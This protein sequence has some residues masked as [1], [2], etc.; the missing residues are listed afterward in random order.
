MRLDAQ[1]VLA[2][3]VVLYG[4]FIAISAGNL[5]TAGI[6]TSDQTFRVVASAVYMTSLALAY[7]IYHGVYDMSKTIYSYEDADM[8]AVVFWT[9]VSLGLIFA[10]YFFLGGYF[11][12]SSTYI[13]TIVSLIYALPIFIALAENMGFIA[14]VGDYVYDRTRNE[15]LSAVVVGLVAVV[16]HATMPLLLPS[17]KFTILFLEFFVWTIASI[18]SRSTLPADLSHVTLNSLFLVLRG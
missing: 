10:I 8:K 9:A 2:V 14:V 3:V 6:L 1:S 11:P 15:L 12:F 18:R 4:I 7:L 17:F 13:Q 16:M 5:Y